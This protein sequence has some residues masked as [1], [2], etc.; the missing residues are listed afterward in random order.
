MNK[1]ERNKRSYLISKSTGMTKIYSKRAFVTNRAKIY[2]RER[3][4]RG[5][6]R[7]YIVVKYLRANGW[8]FENI[9]PEI[10]ELKRQLII[11]NRQIKW[12]ISRT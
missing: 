7:D 9:T 12:Q 10:I 11:L 5:E 8:S 6:L 2:D 1:Q 3:K 4:A